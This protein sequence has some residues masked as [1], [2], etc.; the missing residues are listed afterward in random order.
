MVSGRAGRIKI[1]DAGSTRTSNS[2]FL[3]P[4][5]PRTLPAGPYIM[6]V[7]KGRGT[8]V[9]KRRRMHAAGH[10]C[11]GAGGG[12][13][14]RG[15]LP[16]GA[17]DVSGGIPADRVRLRL[18]PALERSASDADHGVEV[19]QGPQRHFT[20]AVQDLGIIGP[21][22]TYSV[23]RARLRG[24][25]RRRLG[26]EMRRRRPLPPPRPCFQAARCPRR[27]TAGKGRANHGTGI[28]KDLSRRL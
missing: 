6:R 8:Y 19:P 15:D 25:L 1:A 18:L 28:E 27:T 14:D 11:G 16:G 21:G 5:S 23:S 2:Y 13:P 17:A 9:S 7:R 26:R 22:R 4:H 10:L 12:D 24:H 3:T 20:E